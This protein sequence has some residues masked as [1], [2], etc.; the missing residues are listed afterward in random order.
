MFSRLLLALALVLGGTGMSRAV[1]VVMC[2]GPALKQWEGLR[3]QPDRHDN[4]WANF[5]R[6]STVRISQIQQADPGARITWIVYRPGYVTRGKE[7][8]K[9]YTKWISDLAAKY[10]TKLV[11]VNTADQAIR[12][13]NSSPRFQGDKVESFYYFG[14]SNCFAWMLD[15][16]NNIM[17]VSTEW[18]HETDLNRIRRDIFSAVRLSQFRLL[19]GGQHVRLVEASRRRSSLGQYGVHPLRP[20]FQRTPAGRR[21]QVG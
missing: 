2:G 5:V 7:D 19:H 18:I 11:W 9:P 1:H 15:Y 4:W 20:R 17:A 3:I 21:G 6:A 12:A 13:L 16:G 10:K 14:H 8:G